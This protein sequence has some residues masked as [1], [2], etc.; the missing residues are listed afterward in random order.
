MSEESKAQKE[1]RLRR[2]RRQAKIKADSGSRLNK[3]TGT[4]GSFR[5]HE[6]DAAAGGTLHLTYLPSGC[7][8]NPYLCHSFAVSSALSFPTTTI[9]T[10]P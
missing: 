6:L 4:Q 5:D 9:R 3:I 2:E 7:T 10:A 8:T 1:A